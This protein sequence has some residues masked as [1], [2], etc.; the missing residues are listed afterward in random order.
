MLVDLIEKMAFNIAEWKKKIHVTDS[1]WL[2]WR[3]S[4][5]KLV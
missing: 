1:K 5:C 3:F 4:C 2:G